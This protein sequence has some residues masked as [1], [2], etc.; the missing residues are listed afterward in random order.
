LKGIVSKVAAQFRFENLQSEVEKWNTLVVGEDNVCTDVYRTRNQ[1]IYAELIEIDTECA[2]CF[3]FVRQ[4]CPKELLLC[5]Q[6]NS[7]GPIIEQLRIEN[8]RVQQFK[9]LN[10]ASHQ[11]WMLLEDDIHRYMQMASDLSL[12][13]R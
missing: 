6:F 1:Q 13:L 8:E 10:P 7:V 5:F 4:V 3:L 12:S 9:S 2:D 11:Y